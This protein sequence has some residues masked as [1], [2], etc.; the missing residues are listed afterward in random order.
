MNVEAVSW[1]AGRSLALSGVQCRARAR[2]QPAG[3]EIPLYPLDAFTD[4]L[5]GGKSRRGGTLR[6][7]LRGERVGIAGQVVPFLAGTAW[8]PITRSRPAA[9]A[10]GAA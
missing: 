5:F 2:A 9:A 6:C 10:P 8:L 4:R 7:T 3:M 1:V